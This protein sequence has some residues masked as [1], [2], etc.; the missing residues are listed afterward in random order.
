MKVEGC[1]QSQGEKECEVERSVVMVMLTRNPAGPQDLGK[2][3]LG[4]FLSTSFCLRLFCISVHVNLA[5]TLP[6]HRSALDISV[7]TS[8]AVSP[9]RR[10]RVLQCHRTRL[11]PKP[12][13]HPPT[14]R[15]K[16]G[17]MAS[18]SSLR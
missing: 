8:I 15:L 14:H 16:R 18:S 3:R 17:L 6:P 7:A 5:V 1:L 12:P 4:C 2:T 11:T 10:D 13:P 9:F